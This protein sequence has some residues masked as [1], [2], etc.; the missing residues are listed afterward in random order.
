ME[1][2]I[3]M[4]A[5]KERDIIVDSIYKKCINA[6]DGK[7]VIVNQISA[8][9]KAEEIYESMTEEERL[10]IYRDVV[11]FRLANYLYQ[12]TN[13]S[14]LFYYVNGEEVKRSMRMKEWAFYYA[15]TMSLPEK[16]SICEKINL[17]YL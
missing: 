11:D 5:K 13:S 10:R 3:N 16:I 1:R 8:K 9:I 17:K 7:F 15:R 6:S 12:K 2:K 4:I 14:L